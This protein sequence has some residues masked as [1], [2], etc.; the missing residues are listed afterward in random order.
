[1]PSVHESSF[2]ETNVEL[3][4][5]EASESSGVSFASIKQAAENIRGRA[6]VTP[7]LSS[8]LINQIL[9][10]GETEFFFKCEN[11][12]KTGSFKFRGAYNAL[13]CLKESDKG[14]PIVTHSSGNHAQ[15]IAAAAA[16][17]NTTAHVIM[18]QN[19]SRV[20][21]H[22]VKSYGA[23]LTFCRPTTKD[24]VRTAE[25][26]REA[27][28]GILVSPF[29]HPGVVAGQGTVGLELMQ[30]V[31]DL[32]A[33]VVPIGGGGLIS[34][35]AIAAK[36]CNPKV[37]VIGA[38]PTLAST[39]FQSLQAGERL[40]ATGASDTV[41]DGLKSGIGVLGWQV[42]CRLVDKVITVSEEDIIS[43]MKLIWERMKLVIE[44][45]AGVGVAA[46]Q[47]EEF[48][49][50]RFKRVGIILCGGNVDLDHLPWQ[51]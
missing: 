15:A 8:K 34:G 31:K 11:L 45:S 4:V 29:E 28:N 17:H 1:M 12:Q 33:L 7:V 18:P 30:Q 42:V 27:V 20:K 25:Q 6:H 38:E 16:M 36:S 46:V 5:F 22:A 50:L 10:A 21:F 3:L 19:A 26:V 37:V 47:S 32:E 51:N 41:A 24:R 44:P 35:I 23:H 40:Q 39:A 14:R 2:K 13:S 49:E 9:S 43:S 48:R